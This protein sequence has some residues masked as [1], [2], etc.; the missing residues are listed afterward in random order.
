MPNYWWTT[1][2]AW[3]PDKVP[4]DL[5]S[6]DVALGL[7]V[8]RA[9]RR[10]ST[11]SAR[12]SRSPRSAW[13]SIRTRPTTALLDQ[14]LALLEQQK[15]LLRMYTQDDIGDLTSRLAVDDARWSGDYYQML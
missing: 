9:P 8:L 4:G 12:C 1:G 14:S 5:T 13:A 3:N 6:W 10:C 2:F 11:T 15:P 7:A